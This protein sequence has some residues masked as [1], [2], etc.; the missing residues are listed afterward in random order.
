MTD[1]S[2]WK[3]ESGGRCEGVERVVRRGGEEGISVRLL[4]GSECNHSHYLYTSLY[5]SSKSSSA[6][7]SSRFDMGG[8]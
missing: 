1:I 4:A 3:W 2:T 7:F 8:N 5:I 6:F